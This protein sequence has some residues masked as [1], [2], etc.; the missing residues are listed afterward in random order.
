[1]TVAPEDISLRVLNGSGV[2]GAATTAS[3]QLAEQG[4][5]I[6]WV[7]TAET[8]DF[9]STVVRYDPVNE[10]AARTVAASIPGATRVERAGLGTTI[11]VIVGDSWPG[12]EPVVV[13]KPPQPGI[14]TADDDICS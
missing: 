6:A 7:D 10:E 8:S 4:Y 5:V 13:K 11:E 12:V 3:E 2:E 14:R 1:M 9:I